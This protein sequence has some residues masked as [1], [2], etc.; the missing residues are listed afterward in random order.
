M[1]TAQE[2]GKRYTENSLL[3]FLE[4]KGDEKWIVGIMGAS[5][6][7]DIKDAIKTLSYHTN[8]QRLDFIRRTYVVA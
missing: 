7:Q 1:T 5:S 8:T 6:L 3:A 2:A 4:G